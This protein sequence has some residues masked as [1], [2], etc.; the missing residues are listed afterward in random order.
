MFEVVR[1]TLLTSSSPP[2]P[3][4]TIIHPAAPRSLGAAPH[5]GPVLSPRDGQT[6]TCLDTWEVLSYGEKHT[7]GR[8]ATVGCRAQLG[9]GRTGRLPRGRSM[10]GGKVR[11]GVGTGPTQNG[12]WS[13]TRH[14]VGAQLMP[15]E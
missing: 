12:E 11:D 8:G 6:R 14:T 15:G 10:A 9:V 2:G 5:V 1:F 4:P 7:Q 13:C 3:E